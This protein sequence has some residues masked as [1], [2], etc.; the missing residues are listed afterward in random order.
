MQKDKLWRVVRVENQHGHGPYISHELMN[1]YPPIQ[2][3]SSPR[4]P[5]TCNDGID[6]SGGLWSRSYENIRH[7]F[8]SIE[9]LYR[10]FDDAD[11]IRAMQAAGYKIAVYEVHPTY[12]LLGKCQLIFHAKYAERVD[13][14]PLSPEGRE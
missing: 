1:P 3:A 12:A 14:M 6:A 9:K 7:G 13:E 10:W 5:I 8:A 2:G 11:E 4:R